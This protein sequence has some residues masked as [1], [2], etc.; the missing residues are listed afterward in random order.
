M[1]KMEEKEKRPWQLA[2]ER[3]ISA[4]TAKLNRMGY[5]LTQEE[6]AKK[7][8]TKN[9]SKFRTF[10][11]ND[12]E[13]KGNNL[14]VIFSED[15]S[16]YIDIEGKVCSEPQIYMLP[17]IDNYAD[18]Y[19]NLNLQTYGPYAVPIGDFK[20]LPYKEGYEAVKKPRVA[21]TTKVAVGTGVLDLESPGPDV[22]NWDQNFSSM[23]VKD[24]I[25]ILHCYPVSDKAEINE[26]IKRINVSRN[27]G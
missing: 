18:I 14:F 11:L 6:V 16:D 21:K 22:E 9:L 5:H 2:K 4:V 17:K 10:L 13:F 27:K 24:F 23:T 12:Y 7:A 3:S 25:A 1:F 8:V 15:Y 19:Q 26:I 20:V